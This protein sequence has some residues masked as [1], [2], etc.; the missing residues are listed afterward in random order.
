MESFDST[1]DQYRFTALHYETLIGDKA[2]RESVR[3]NNL[4]FAANP[5]ARTNLIVTRA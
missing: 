5:F 1:E 4:K 3:V 2:G